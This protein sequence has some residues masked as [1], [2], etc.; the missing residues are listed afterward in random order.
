M[1]ELIKIKLDTL[2]KKPG[3]Y[4][5]KDKYG[6]I[7]YVG[8][9][10]NLYNRVRS[11]FI[12][13]HDAKTT[14][15]VSEIC[16]LEYIITS[17]ETE[18]LILEI[19]LIKK[20][21]PKYNILLTD[22]K[23]YPYIV[24]TNEKHPRIIY[25]REIKSFKGNVYG[26]YPN[27]RAAKEVVDLLNRIY[28]FRKCNKIPNK[29]CLYYHINQCLAPCINKIDKKEYENLRNKL[30]SILKGNVNEE[31]K[32]LTALMN[33]AS[34]ELNFEK[35][36]EY[37]N[38]I[39][40]LTSVS[41]KQKMEGY[42]DDIDCFAYY[43]SDD[44]I[45]IQVFHLRESKL[46]ERN[47]FLFENNANPE[48]IFTDFIYKFYLINNNPVP[49]NIYISEG[50]IEEM[51]NVFRSYNYNVSVYIPKIGKK[52][53]LINLVKDNAKNKIDELI[54]K[55][56]IEYQKTNGACEELS[57]LL[58]FEVHSIEA[59]DNSN[60][61]GASPVSAMV[62]FVDGKANKKN[63]RKYKIKTVVGA[64]E[65]QTMYEVVTRRYKDLDI[66]P[67]LIIM[68]GGL[69]QI[70]ACKKALSDINKDIK[71]VGLVKDD[72]HKTKALIYESKEL[73]IDKRSFLFRMLEFIQEEV[74]RYAITFFRN[75]HGKNAFSSKLDNIKGV[76]KVKKNM[77]MKILASDN[78][79]EE[80]NKLNLSEVIKA[81][82]LKIYKQ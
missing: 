49:K 79:E 30:H 65:A 13:S 4:Q 81:E 61:Q 8:K 17:T 47:A 69:I 27:A 39:D 82:V 15:L 38:I 73:E 55:N 24:L 51:E 63:Y 62:S 32:T 67:D 71:V 44:Y 33:Q 34:I 46:L 5:Y 60:I 36:I 23:R 54:K 56:D 22:D 28:P 77:I 50:N 70:N 9:A 53:E 3:S 10:K 26:P 66:L 20:Y 31:I 80:L 18:A 57:A 25:T 45:S 19:N 48:D 40:A 43:A 75:T 29:E 72:K 58:G 41:E 64:N 42:L 16:D 35:A 74:H 52:K 11:Y 37:R 76:G 1:N 78:F 68:D 2:P 6:E 7:I 21:N 12:G 14:K 59:F